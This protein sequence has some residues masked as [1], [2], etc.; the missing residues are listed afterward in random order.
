[1]TGWEGPLSGV[2]RRLCHQNLS[3]LRDRRLQRILTLAGHELHLG[4]PR[5]GDGVAVWG[6]SP[7]AW[8]GAWAV[9]RTDRLDC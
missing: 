9:A 7:T 6:S 5:P 2:P 3:F 1:M 8:R 4:L